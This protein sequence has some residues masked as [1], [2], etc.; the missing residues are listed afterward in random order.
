[1]SDD[2]Y[3]LWVSED[4]C[5]FVRVWASGTVEVARRETPAH[6][7]GPPVELSEEDV[8]AHTRA[9]LDFGSAA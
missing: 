8:Q 4:R 5:T 1:M 7:W 6:T 3:R 9:A 2:G